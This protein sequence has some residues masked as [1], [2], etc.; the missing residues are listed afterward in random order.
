MPNIENLNPK[1]FIEDNRLNVRREDVLYREDLR[2]GFF[3]S[4]I[5]ITISLAVAGGI[6]TI[7]KKLLA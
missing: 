2:A 1:S 7:G 3:Y 5:G 6:Y 4:L